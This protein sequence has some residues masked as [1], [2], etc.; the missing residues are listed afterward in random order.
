MNI[1]YRAEFIRGFGTYKLRNETLRSALEYALKIGYRAIDTA[2]MYNN[3]RD[4]GQVLSHYPVARSELCI[5]T[6]VLPANYHSSLFMAS[7]E[8]SLQALNLEQVDVLLL[9]SPPKQDFDATLRLLEQAQKHGLTKHIGLSNFS[10]AQMAQAREAIATPLIVNQV[11][12]HPLL[13]QSELL[14]A[15]VE[16]NIP[17]SSYC[18]IARGEALQYPLIQ[19]LAKRYAK[20]P[21]QIILRWILQSGIQS[22]TMS[23]NPERIKDNFAILDFNLS[24]IDMQQISQLKSANYRVVAL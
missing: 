5:T 2:Q 24:H 6:K 17:L 15:A 8:Q 9:H 14:E 19:T 22:N 10:P 11:E 7:V 13:D 23:S 16:T 20:T 1:L 4:I 21:A 3:E 18:S 12:F